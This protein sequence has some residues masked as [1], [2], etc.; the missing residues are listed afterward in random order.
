MEHQYKWD[1]QKSNNTNGTFVSS[2]IDTKIKQ[3]TLKLIS[4]QQQEIETRKKL[5]ES[6]NV[7]AMFAIIGIILTIVIGALFIFGV[8][9]LGASTSSIVGGCIPLL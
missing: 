7:L 1:N 5:E 9:G 6:L 2:D 8:I 4:K 3:E